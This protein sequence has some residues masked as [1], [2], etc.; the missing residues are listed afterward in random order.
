M[1]VWGKTPSQDENVNRTKSADARHKDRPAKP[2]AGESGQTTVMMALFMA[3][4]LLGFVAIAVDVQ[5]LFHSKRQAQAAADAAAMAAAEEVN[6]GTAAEQA[7]ANAMAKLNGFD[8]TL[9]IN[10]ATVTLGVPSGGNYSGSSSYI[11]AVVSQPIS[12]F[13]ARAIKKGPTCYRERPGGCR[14]WAEQ[15]DLRLPGGRDRNRP[16]L[17]RQLQGQP[18][19]LWDYRRLSKN[20]AVTI[21][22]GTPCSS[23]RRLACI[24]RTG[25]KRSNVTSGGSVASGHKIIQGIGAACSPRHYPRYSNL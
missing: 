14:I 15:P 4:F 21:V 20:N 8:T 13:F 23:G 19:L 10:P 25:Y 5:V 3:T 16:E 9:A 7:A 1:N 18:Q 22:S 12:A 11:Q 6:N 2:H 24:E 17:E